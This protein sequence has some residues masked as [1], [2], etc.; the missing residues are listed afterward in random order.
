MGKKFTQKKPNR[1][2]DDKVFHR[3]EEH[4][5]SFSSLSPFPLFFLFFP[6]FPFFPFFLGPK[7]REKEYMHACNKLPQTIFILLAL[8]RSKPK[9][10]PNIMPAATLT[11]YRDSLSLL[12]ER[13]PWRG[14]EERR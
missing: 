2:T 5:V 13:E 6:F 10:K 7:R 9:P 3:Q 8:C 14:G 4:K 1:K 11:A 12:D